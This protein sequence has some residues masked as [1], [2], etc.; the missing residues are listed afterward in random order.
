MSR[1]SCLG[2]GH[3]KSIHYKKLVCHLP[4]GRVVAA[5]SSLWSLVFLWHEK[6]C[7]RLIL[8]LFP[9][10]LMDKLS[11]PKSNTFFTELKPPVILVIYGIKLMFLSLVGIALQSH[12]VTMVITAN[13]IAFH[14]STLPSR[15]LP[16]EPLFA[17]RCLKSSGSVT[18]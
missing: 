8:T 11:T 10:S 4:K 7:P 14:P 9:T 15:N 17:Y 3:R 16:P 13:C 2:H 5:S 12:L 18:A 6:Y 1:S